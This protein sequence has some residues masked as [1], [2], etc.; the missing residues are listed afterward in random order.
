MPGSNP[1]K[2]LFQSRLVA[3]GEFRCAPD[4]PLWRRENRIADGHNIV[5]PRTFVLIRP[6]GQASVVSSPN[7]VMLYHDGQC[8]ERGLVTPEGDAC[9]WVV[10]R[11]DVLLDILTAHDP[12]AAD[13]PARPF[14]T[15]H[16]PSDNTAY[17]LQR[18]VHHALRA[19]QTADALAVEEFL[20]E[21]VRRQVATLYGALRERP[22]RRASSE[23][24]DRTIAGDAGRLLGRRFREPL[25]LE[26]IASACGCSVFHLC[27]VFRRHAGM[28]VHRFL[29]RLR[30]RAGL[31]ALPERAVELAGLAIDLGFSSQSHFTDAFRAEFGLSP[32]RLR[33]LLRRGLRPPESQT[34]QDS[35]RSPVGD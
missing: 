28:P 22:R 25:S 21:A 9:E 14:P 34:E 10:L 30:V 27:R 17:L 16:A 35:G 13:R 15:G 24:R 31:Q 20:I 19:G 23:H 4:D 26:E 33:D 8:Y 12:R 3:C 32:G 5:F 29:R 18:R 1:S 2:R 11:S 7:T 6:A